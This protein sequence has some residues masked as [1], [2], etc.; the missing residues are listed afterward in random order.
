MTV[1]LSMPLG[2]EALIAGEDK[3]EGQSF[4]WLRER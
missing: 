3:K 1:N 4:D 2:C